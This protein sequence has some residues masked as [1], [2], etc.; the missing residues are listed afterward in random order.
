MKYS[1]SRRE[2]QNS[3]VSPPSIDRSR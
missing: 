3:A 2:P 1:I